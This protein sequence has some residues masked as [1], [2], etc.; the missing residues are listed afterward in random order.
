MFYWKSCR[1]LWQKIIYFITLSSPE[2]YH[3]LLIAP[4]SVNLPG[5]LLLNTDTIL[6]HFRSR[7][8][9]LIFPLKPLIFDWV[10][11][12][13]SVYSTLLKAQDYHWLNTE[14]RL[15]HLRSLST[16]QEKQQQQEMISIGLVRLFFPA[17]LRVLFLLSNLW[18]QALLLIP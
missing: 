9:T 2:A 13:C 11:T 8:L 14:T 5:C 6:S 18:F 7:A 12:D 10:L 17:C 1:P 3:L 15:F 4:L 16:S